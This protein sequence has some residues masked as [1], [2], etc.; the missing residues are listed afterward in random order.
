MTKATSA[1]GNL[2]SR[3][4]ISE[5]ELNAV[6]DRVSDALS[7][8]QEVIDFMKSLSATLPRYLK[9]VAPETN[10]LIAAINSATVSITEIVEIKSGPIKSN[11]SGASVTITEQHKINLGINNSTIALKNTLSTIDSL[12]S[13]V[14]MKLR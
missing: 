5:A 14:E 7:G 11:S 12:L 13:Q 9:E 1:L 2:K 8:V 6:L 4:D 10:S 3:N